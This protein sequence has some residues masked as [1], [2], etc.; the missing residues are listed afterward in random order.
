MANAFDVWF[1]AADTVY[2]A[3]PYAV[4][5]G[6]AE[7]GRLAADDKV[8]PAGVTSAWTRVGDHPL[9][10]DYLFAPSP[11][12]PTDLAE[13]LHEVEMDIPPRKA[14]ED[15]DDNDNDVDMIPLID[16][17]MVLLI[18]F[19]MTATVAA[20]STVE[21]PAMKHAGDISNA[22]DALT[23]QIDKRP[24]GDVFYAVRVGELPPANAD[25]NLTTKDEIVARLKA[26][27]QGAEQPPEVR[28]A[29]HKELPRALVH[30][31]AKELHTLKEDKRIAFY[32]A[33]VAELK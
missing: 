24:G 25:N 33:E 21:L 28:I 19:M 5:T 26:H 22:A 27:L 17:S 23:V 11:D 31:V 6:W 30:D 1:V 18:F 10:S 3:V 20:V 14:A 32:G 12:A 7:Q 13:Q 29:C 16:I 15:D 4:A 2:K 8:R 9:L